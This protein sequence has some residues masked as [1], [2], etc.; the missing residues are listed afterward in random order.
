MELPVTAFTNTNAEQSV[1]FSD[2]LQ[3]DGADSVINESINDSVNSYQS[4][5]EVDSQPVRAVLIPS[6]VQG[7][8]GSPLQLEVDVTCNTRAPSCIP[9]CAVT[10]P[11]SAWNK[12][13]SIHT[14]L[15]QIGP[16]IMILSEHWGRKKSFE[17][18]LASQ[19]FKVKE[20]SRG[21]RGIPTKGRNGK[22][23]TSVTGGGVA[24]VYGE[25]NFFVEDAVIEAP[26]GIEAVWVI[27]TPKKKEMVGVNKI[28][29][30]GVYISPC[31][32]FKQQTTDHIIATMFSVQSRHESQVFFFDSR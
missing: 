30:G 23:K 22:P 27:L 18:A 1:Q 19:H 29:V 25:E 3:C 7:P 10:N 24:I 14:F 21:I 31:S 2:I 11:R 8:C 28:L 15:R 6:S 16:D 4:E 13:H 26:E 9:L 32:K 20:S 5:N 17:K 12:I